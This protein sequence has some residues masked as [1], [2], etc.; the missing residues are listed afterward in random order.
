MID[1]NNQREI[2]EFIRDHV[3]EHKQFALAT[4]GQDGQPW[5][6]CLNLAYDEQFNIIWKSEKDT[7][8]SQHVRAN[9][10]AAICI[11]SEDTERGDFG[12]YAKAQAQEISDEQE[13]KRLLQIRFGRKGKPVPPIGSFIDD[14]TS[15]I[16][17]AQIKE[18]YFNDN[19]H[20]KT[21]VDLEVLRQV[22]SQ[23][24]GEL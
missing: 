20:L 12:L 22:I 10:S 1:L 9:P 16:Y 3:D 18:M 24:R 17:Y 11:F 7:V 15:R 23:N 21:K 5:L 8:H 19:R 6:V 4:V 14:A 2:A 13:L